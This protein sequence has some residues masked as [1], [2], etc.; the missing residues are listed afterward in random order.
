[1]DII[2]SPGSP[3]AEQLIAALKRIK[4]SDLGLVEPIDM[5]DWVRTYIGMCPNNIIVFPFNR[6]GAVRVCRSAVG[7]V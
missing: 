6:F 3:Y 7:Q 4:C 1:M 5:H 2:A